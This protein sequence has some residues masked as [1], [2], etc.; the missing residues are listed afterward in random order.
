MT[1]TSVWSRL[2]ELVADEATANGADGDRH[3]APRTATDEA[4]QPAADQR[5]PDGA[6][7]VGHVLHRLR[8]DRFDAADAA[9]RG[10]AH[11]VRRRRV[12]AREQQH[13]HRGHRG[14]TVAVKTDRVHCHSP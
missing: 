1:H 4:A 9:H 10:L 7:R 6:D 8:L 2:R 14:G 5:A 13:R 12:A 11:L 3:R